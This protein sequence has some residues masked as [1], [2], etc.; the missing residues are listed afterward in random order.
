MSWA[1]TEVCWVCLGEGTDLEPLSYPC[2]CP[3]PVHGACLARW[4][5]HSA[6]SRSVTSPS[7]LLKYLS[8]GRLCGDLK[9]TFTLHGRYK[10]I[11]LI[12]VGFSCQHTIRALHRHGHA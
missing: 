5:L 2:K 4:Q 8:Y 12:A 1:Q 11:A 10:K 6:G 9:V 3:R 7:C